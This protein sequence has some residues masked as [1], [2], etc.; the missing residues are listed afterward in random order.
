MKPCHWFCIT[1]VYLLDWSSWPWRSWQPDDTCLAKVTTSDFFY[2]CQMGMNCDAWFCWCWCEMIPTN[3]VAFRLQD[4]IHVKPN[5]PVFSLTVVDGNQTI[6]GFQVHPVTFDFRLLQSENF[7]NP[8]C[9][10]W[11]YSH[12]WVDLQCGRWW[13]N[14]VLSTTGGCTATKEVSFQ[15]TGVNALPQVLHLL[16]LPNYQCSGMVFAN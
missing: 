8:Q 2:L 9:A 4:D 3:I 10:Y 14:V 16:S 15:T 5:T 11:K 1:T 6:E 12:R 13:E 7:S